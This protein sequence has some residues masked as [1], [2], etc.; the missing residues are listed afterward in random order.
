MSKLEAFKGRIGQS[1]ILRV[2]RDKNRRV[3]CDFNPCKKHKRFDER[4]FLKGLE[5]LEER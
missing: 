4:E 1:V 5:K 2:F 3:I